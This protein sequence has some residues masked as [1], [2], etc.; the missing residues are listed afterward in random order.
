[1]VSA[2]EYD[3]L[4]AEEVLEEEQK[5][6]FIRRLEKVVGSKTVGR[7][8]R[9]NQRV[10]QPVQRDRRSS[11]ARVDWKPVYQERYKDLEKSRGQVRNWLLARRAMTPFERKQKLARE[12]LESDRELARMD[13]DFLDDYDG[14]FYAAALE[15]FK[16][17]KI[18]PPPGA[19]S[20]TKKLVQD[21]DESGSAG[22]SEPSGGETTPAQSNE[23]L[24]PASESDAKRERYM[25]YREE[26][27]R[28]YDPYGPEMPAPDV[29][30]YG[31]ARS[32]GL[33]KPFWLPPFPEEHIQPT[34]DIIQKYLN[35]GYTATG[36][37]SYMTKVKE[38][39]AEQ[40][41]APP[42]GS[43][44]KKW[45]TNQIREFVARFKLKKKSVPAPQKVLDEA[46]WKK[47]FPVLREVS[48]EESS[49][50]SQDDHDERYEEL[51]R[52]RQNISSLPPPPSDMLVNA[53]KAEG[54]TLAA[55][56]KAQK[57]A[58]QIKQ[59]KSRRAYLKSVRDRVQA[60]RD[61]YNPLLTYQDRRAAR[62]ILRGR[63]IRFATDTKPDEGYESRRLARKAE[64]D[65]IRRNALAENG[66]GTIY[67]D[68]TRSS[69]SKPRTGRRL[70]RS[71]IS[72]DDTRS[73]PRRVEIDSSEG[74]STEEM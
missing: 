43:K 28:N 73:G 24:L 4:S 40:G 48:D 1:M 9:F 10:V 71:A 64:K 6:K 33:P 17:S 46:D 63:T 31:E 55:E 27:E 42:P 58:E 7:Q 25:K 18:P 3:E 30:A 11:P 38:A 14:D 32:L 39:L 54:N 51:E 34:K 44:R 21:F 72:D 23:E 2:D 29:S 50:D 68:R 19:S 20:W 53:L 5:R 67:K 70:D 69:R 41:I 37:K 22:F 15:S 45:T 8:R 12:L 59:R 16:Q 65:E 56:L 74:S 66:R 36:K 62:K 47:K 61:A 52:L 57:E 60:G 26:Q 49:S 13:D 35:A